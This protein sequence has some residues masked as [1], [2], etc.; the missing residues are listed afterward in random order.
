MLEDPNRSHPVS[1]V[2]KPLYGTDISPRLCGKDF[3][4]CL[5]PLDRT[6][7]AITAAARRAHSQRGARQ[8][9]RASLEHQHGMSHW[10]GNGDNL[11][12]AVTYV[13]Q[14]LLLPKLGWLGS[15]PLGPRRG[16]CVP[17]RTGCRVG[18]TA[19]LSH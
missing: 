3:P 15:Q 14:H 8:T 7:S 19:N 5:L 1:C 10:L 4:V 18:I 2:N 11:E 12:Q 13:D 16:Q 9:S 6:P 17:S